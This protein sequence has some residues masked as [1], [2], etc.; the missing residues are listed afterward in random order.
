MLTEPAK[1]ACSRCKQTL[2]LTDFYPHRRM[3]SGRQSHCKAC[4]RAWHKERPGYVRRKNAEWKAKNPSYPR[5]WQL[6][7]KYGLTRDEV[8]AIRARQ[9]HRCAGC[10]T[11]LAGIKECVDHCH[12][13]GNVRGILCNGCNFV[14]GHVKD[15]IE[16]LRRLAAYLTRL[17]AEVY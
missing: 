15:D 6:K 5:D 17:E 1:K 12:A 2:P 10:L 9:D 11:P 8:E 4:A 13:T 16:T 14:L 7:N 3:R